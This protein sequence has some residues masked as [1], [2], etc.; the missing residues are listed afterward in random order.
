MLKDMPKNTG[1]KGQKLTGTK[2]VPVRDTTPTLADLGLGR[3]LKDM[4]KADGGTAQRTR[5]QK[6]T[7]LEP[8]TLADLGLDRMLKEMPKNIGS[9][10]GGKKKSSRGTYLEPRDKTPTLA[11]LGLDCGRLLS[12]D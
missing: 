7:E 4:P 6:S 12:A 10:G 2:M 1:L 9:A 3:M 5:F 8:P 11:D